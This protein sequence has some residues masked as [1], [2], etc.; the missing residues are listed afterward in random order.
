[1]YSI[2]A[3]VTM[4]HWLRK[5]RF[6]VVNAVC[7]YCD[8]RCTTGIPGECLATRYFEGERLEKALAGLGFDPVQSLGSKCCM[9]LQ[10]PS[11]Y[12]NGNA[13]F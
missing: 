10:G 12:E 7:F 2:D 8:G 1:M 4:L 5:N 13:L 9:C 3:F 11:G 6:S